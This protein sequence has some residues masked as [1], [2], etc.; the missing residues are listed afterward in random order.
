VQLLYGNHIS[1]FAGRIF[2][3]QG[4]IGGT[5]EAIQQR[6][7]GKDLIILLQLPQICLSAEKLIV[8]KD[9]PGILTADPLFF[10]MQKN[11]TRSLTRRRLNSLFS[12]P[13]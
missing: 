4:F 7:E 2:I 8:W 1:S 9:V 6:W 5:K 13:R 10:R 12:A 11:L 3:T